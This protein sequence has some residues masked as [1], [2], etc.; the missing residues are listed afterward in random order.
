MTSLNYPL[1]V[2]ALAWLLAGCAGVEPVDTDEPVELP[3]EPGASQLGLS[4]GGGTA[5]GE[6][7]LADLTIGDPITHRALV[8]ARFTLELGIGTAKPMKEQP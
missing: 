5:E 4:G 2:F 3:P 6:L 8:G 1:G 7:H